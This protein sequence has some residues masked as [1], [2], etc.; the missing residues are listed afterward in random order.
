MEDDSEN[1][2]E[3]DGVVATTESGV[4]DIPAVKGERVTIP[5]APTPTIADG[6]VKAMSAPAVSEEASKRSQLAWS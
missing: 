3:I 4:E 6:K 2:V 1:G 5:G